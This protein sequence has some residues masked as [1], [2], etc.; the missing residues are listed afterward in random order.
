MNMA[1]IYEI[2][3][4]AFTISTNT[5]RLNVDVIHSFLV[6]SYWKPGIPRDVVVKSIKNSF[7]FG[8]YHGDEQIGFAS[9]VT[10]FTH[11]AY[12]QDVFIVEAYRGRQLGQ[13][14]IETIVACPALQG[15]GTMILATRDAHG[16]YRKYGFNDL[17]SP[18]KWL[19]RS[20]D[21]PW[22]DPQLVKDNV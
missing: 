13:W 6:T 19:V 9:V 20:F 7:C 22:I 12:I 2:Q 8:V 17:K 1:P 4:N 11:F 10:D 3:R 18:K 16:L 21:R 15:I 14:L 5:D